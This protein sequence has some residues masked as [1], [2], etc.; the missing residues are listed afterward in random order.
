M[1]VLK[2]RGKGCD[3]MEKASAVGGGEEERRRGGGG[4]RG[5]RRGGEGKGREGRAAAV[6]TSV[7]GCGGG[8]ELESAVAVVGGEVGPFAYA[9]S[10]LLHPFYSS[11]PCIPLPSLHDN[12]LSHSPS[13]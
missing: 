2:Q 4:G 11:L 6:M 12:S 9:I 8:L 13:F 10:L 7:R 3:C 1:K 5:G